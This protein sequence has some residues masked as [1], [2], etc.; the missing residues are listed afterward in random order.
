M[1]QTPTLLFDGDCGF[2]RKWIAYWKSL[3]GE[4]VQYVTYQKAGANFPDIKNKEL[5]QAV[6]FVD[7]DGTVKGA[8]AVFK[9]LTYANKNWGLWLYKK[10]PG[11][12]PVTEFFYRLVAN[13][14]V[15]FSFLTKHI[16]GDQINPAKHDLVRWLFLRAFGII[17]LLVFLSLIPQ[18]LG[19]YG[20]NGIAPISDFLTQVSSQLGVSKWWKFPTLFWFFSSDTALYLS[21]IV[22]CAFSILLILNQLTLLSLIGIWVLYL[23]ILN[24][25]Q[26]F[27]SFQW[28]I[29][30]VEIGFLAIL[31]AAF[32]SPSTAILWLLRILLFRFML[33]AGLVKI[34][35]GEPA[36][37]DLTALS[38]HYLT[39]PIPHALSW[40][41]HQLPMWFHKFS[42][43]FSYVIELICPFFIFLPGRLRLISFFGTASLMILIFFT[44]NYGFFNLLV[45][46]LCIPLLHD[47]LIK[48]WVK[49]PIETKVSSRGHIFYSLFFV[50]FITLSFSYETIRFGFWQ[51]PPTL[52]RAPLKAIQ[53]FHI[54]NGYGPFSVMTKK[55][56]EIEFEGSNDGIVWKSYPFKWKP[57][58]VSLAPKWVQP[59]HPRLDWQMW[60]VPLSRP[61]NSPWI[62]STALRLLQGSDQVTSLF[63]DNPFKD[64]PPKYIRTVAYDYTFTEPETKKLTGDWWS[65]KLAGQF[66][67]V[68]SLKGI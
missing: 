44:G 42:A 46:V 10:V 68:M 56:Y 31:W 17:S 7:S 41:I 11:F 55:R 32:K 15:L 36:W 28:D 2:C 24:T 51:K 29:F 18:Y 27:L 54:I 52:I 3:T 61:N 63:A 58:D 1:T 20:S 65:R 34:I 9:S 21:L 57:Q 30:F 4:K 22:G 5:E 45:L 13:H 59:Y 50:L 35:S 23:S 12:K 37:R 40:Y 19:L 25:G 6:H 53:P 33:G 67:P 48:K 26:V 62:Y 49:V 16:Y 47:D 66:T 8:E 39:Q 60:F 38:Y 43:V 14:R 64:K